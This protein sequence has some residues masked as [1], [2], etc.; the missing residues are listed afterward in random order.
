MTELTFSKTILLVEDSPPDQVLTSQVV[1][2]AYPHVDVVIAKSMRD[3]Y[4]VCKKQKFDLVLLDLNLPD[5]YGPASVNELR[6]FAPKVPVVVLTGLGSELTKSEAER[7][8]ADTVV[9]K[10]KLVGK[11][12]PEILEPYL[13]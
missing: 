1:K 7:F 11:Q 12:F 6:R 2:S 10:H 3:A 4:E 8:G 9:L 5:A 13:A